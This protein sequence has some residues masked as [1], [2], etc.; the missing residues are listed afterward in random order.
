MS[1]RDC[2]KLVQDRLQW[3]LKQYFVA[4]TFT[5]LYHLSLDMA[6]YDRARAMWT[7]TRSSAHKGSYC[8]KVAKI[9]A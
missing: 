8:H 4:T 7:S 6:K 9:L 3:P 5:D 2:V 1:K